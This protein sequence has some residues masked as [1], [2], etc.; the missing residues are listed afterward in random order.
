MNCPH[1]QANADRL[2]LLLTSS[3]GAAATVLLI[4]RAEGRVAPAGAAMPSAYWAA[5]SRRRAVPL[6]PQLGCTRLLPVPSKLRRAAEHSTRD[7]SIS[8]E[9]PPDDLP[10]H[11]LRPI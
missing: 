11:A 9:N 5:A 10:R 8:N 4:T 7:S 1:R 2:F 6:A 3:A